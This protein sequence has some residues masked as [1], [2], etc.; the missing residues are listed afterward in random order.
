MKNNIDAI[1]NFVHFC[2]TAFL[3]Q[4]NKL[5]LIGIFKNIQTSQFP[6]TYPKISCALSLNI[7]KESRL[8]IQ[9]LCQKSRELITK[10]E[11]NLT[12][13]KDT[14]QSV[15]IGFIADFQGIRFEKSGQYDL[16]VWI[17]NELIDTQSFFIQEVKN[18][19]K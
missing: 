5:N 19:K 10:M 17:N 15:E 6:F 18:E 12:P 2:D 11:G 4:D 7:R 1:L 8:K 13:S 14:D 9:I 3:S 16:E